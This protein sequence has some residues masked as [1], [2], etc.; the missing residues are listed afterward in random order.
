M[1]LAARIEEFVDIPEGVDITVDG[2]TV[3]VKG[4]KGTLTREF[5]TKE[6]VHIDKEGNR[7]K[8]WALF[9]R[10][11]TK[12]MIGTIR[13]HI[14]NMITGVTKGYVYKLRI[15]YRHFPMNVSVEGNK[16]VIKNFLGEKHPRYAD[17]LDGV[18]VKVKGK[19]EIIVEGID[20][21]RVGQTA[22]NIEQATI[23]KKK[24]PRVFVDG[25]Y[26][27]EKGVAHE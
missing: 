16:V 14:N 11:K 6:E 1:V 13:A 27:V 19:E 7:I 26:I 2:L 18:T 22:A 25:I 4:P 9:P 10:R 17:I 15:H 21:E 24:D 12:A 5:K 3:T 20:K 23:V 8:I